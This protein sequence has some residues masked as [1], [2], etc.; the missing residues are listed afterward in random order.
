[1]KITRCSKCGSRNHSFIDCSKTGSWK[2]TKEQLAADASE[3]AAFNT[4]APIPVPEPKP[5]GQVFESCERWLGAPKI[6]L[7]TNLP[8]FETPNELHT[9]H[10]RNS[11]RC[12]IEVAD[13]PCGACGCWHCVSTAPSPSGDSSGTGRVSVLPTGFVPFRRKAF[14]AKRPGG[15]KLVLGA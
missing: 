9:F 6:C 8:A 4:A 12:H 5:R 10:D 2:P 7:A 11:P 14:T 3:E 1:M 13:E 15:G